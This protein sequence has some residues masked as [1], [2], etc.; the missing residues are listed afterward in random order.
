MHSLANGLQVHL[1]TCRRC[2]DDLPHFQLVQTLY[3]KPFYRP[4]EPIDNA[5]FAGA[6]RTTLL[7]LR[8]KFP[9]PEGALADVTLTISHRMRMAVNTVVNEIQQQNHSEKQW[10]PWDREPL[11]GFTMQP[12]SLWTWKG[13]EVFGC[14]RKS[15]GKLIVNGFS[16]TLTD[17]DAEKVNTQGLPR[18][19]QEGRRR[20]SSRGRRRGSRCR[21]RMRRRRSQ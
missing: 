2:V 11:P 4:G 16:Y 14:T 10:M 13:L 7:E 15:A 21:R 3:D 19:R 20:R 18:I 9:M 12:Q 17:F 1:S 8:P 6:L 5:L